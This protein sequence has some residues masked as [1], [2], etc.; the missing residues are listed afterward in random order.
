MPMWL[1][2]KDEAGM[3]WM[4]NTEHVLAIRVDKNAMHV[5]L[6][7]ALPPE[8]GQVPVRVFATEGEAATTL[9][10]IRDAL[11]EGAHVF[12]MRAERVGV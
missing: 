7:V 12:T 3:D 5:L 1:D 10:R 6:P 11:H 8:S 9:R 4:I 2:F